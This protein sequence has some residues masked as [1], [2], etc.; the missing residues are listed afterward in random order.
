M[1]DD[2]TEKTQEPIEE[3]VANAIVPDDRGLKQVGRFRP[4]H[5]GNPLG[6]P[7]GSLNRT[8]LAAAALLDGEAEE[9][10]RTVIEL[11]RNRDMAALRLCLERILP[12]RRERLIQIELPPLRKASDARKAMAAI[13][14]AVA[15]GEITTS[16]ATELAK[17]V[18]TF[19][20]A[21]E[22]SDFE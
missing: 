2:I 19:L 17:L 11:A 18:E 8:T 21:L 5:S 15:N 7:K 1:D 13:T 16:E 22:A 3:H 9:L 14:A 4:G 20:R 12:P 6:R 10:T